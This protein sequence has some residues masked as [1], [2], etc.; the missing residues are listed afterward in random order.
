M[1]HCLSD[2]Q[3][4]L[5]SNK[6][7]Y[8]SHM[9]MYQTGFAIFFFIIPLL[10]SGAAV[11]A[12]SRQRA[13]SWLWERLP[14]CVPVTHGVSTCLACRPSGIIC[15]PLQPG[16]ASLCEVERGERASGKGRG[17]PNSES[18]LKKFRRNV[19]KVFNCS[20]CIRM[21]FLSFMLLFE[22]QL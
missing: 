22:G 16:S 8:A 9:Y 17:Y 7:L 18:Q 19:V 13:V 6:Q 10:T 11:A 15:D 20:C 1:E 3:V 5:T 12:M 2:V 14:E 4:L 21:K